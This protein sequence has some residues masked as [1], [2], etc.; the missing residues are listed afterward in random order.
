[1]SKPFSIAQDESFLVTRE[2]K[3]GNRPVFEHGCL[4]PTQISHFS[5]EFGAREWIIVFVDRLWARD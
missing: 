5:S 3:Q 2:K 4:T 1:L